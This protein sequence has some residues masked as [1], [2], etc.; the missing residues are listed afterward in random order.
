MLLRIAALIAAAV[1]GLAAVK[2]G[3]VLERAGLVGSCTTVA[4]PGRASEAWQACRPGRLEGRPNLT[5]QSCISHG[6]SRELE[7]WRCPNPLVEPP[8]APAVAVLAPAG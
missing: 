5:R 8:A 4:V 1:A 6:V 3:D 2:D 7:Y